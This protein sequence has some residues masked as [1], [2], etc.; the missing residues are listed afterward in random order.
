MLKRLRLILGPSFHCWLF[1]GR[2]F[3]RSFYPRSSNHDY[4]GEKCSAAYFNVQGVL[5][6]RAQKVRALTDPNIVLFL[7]S[8]LVNGCDLIVCIRLFC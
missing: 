4:D 2:G 3:T 1:D 8:G 5:R 7:I 6:E